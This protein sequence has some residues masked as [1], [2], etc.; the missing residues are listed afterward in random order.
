MEEPVL[1]RLKRKLT[2][3]NLWIYVIAA[4]LRHGPQYAYTIKKILQEEYGIKPATITVYTVI[5]RMEKQGLLERLDDNTYRVTERGVEAYSKG[6]AII[7]ETLE[8]LE[9]VKPQF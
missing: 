6:I 9:E 1:D 2:I 7:R 3:E 8:R 5:Y 4:I